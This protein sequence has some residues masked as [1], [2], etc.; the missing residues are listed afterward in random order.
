MGVSQNEQYID[1]ITEKHL[2]TRRILSRDAAALRKP[3]HVGWK[4]M[5]VPKQVPKRLLQ[6]WWL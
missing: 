3:I 2:D 6:G 4:A 5:Q 1:M